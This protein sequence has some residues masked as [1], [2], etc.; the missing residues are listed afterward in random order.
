MYDNNGRFYSDPRDSFDFWDVVDIIHVVCI[1]TVVIIVTHFLFMMPSMR[2]Q[3]DTDARE[4]TRNITPEVFYTT[5]RDAYHD[6]HAECATRTEGRID[7]S[8]CVFPRDEGK[9]GDTITEMLRGPQKDVRQ[10]YQSYTDTTYLYMS[11][12]TLSYNALVTD[13]STSSPD[14]RELVFISVGFGDGYGFGNNDN[15][16]I[17]RAHCAD[18]GVNSAFSTMEKKTTEIAR[19]KETRPYY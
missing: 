17:L 18:M 12:C 16:D 14:D 6:P 3:A 13:V 19:M 9:G 8:T 2:Q 5:S 1:V 15:P 4:S 11:P 7:I 10:H